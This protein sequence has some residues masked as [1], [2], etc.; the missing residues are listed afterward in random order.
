MKDVSVELKVGIFAV[1]VVMVL[2]YM[3]FKVGSLPMIWDK[4]YRL[5]CCSM[6]RADLTRNHA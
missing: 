6:T 4:G 5:S 3:T 2:T 1:I